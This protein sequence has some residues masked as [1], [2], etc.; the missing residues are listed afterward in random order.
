M[1]HTTTQR[2]R[3]RAGL[4][5]LLGAGLIAGGQAT[6]AAAPKPDDPVVDALER[7]AEPL[8]TTEPGGAI[9]DLKPLGDMVGDASVVTT[10]EATHSSHEF[11]TMQ[12][13]IFRYL[14]EEK[15]FRTF[16]RE[17]SWSTGLLLDEYIQTGK[18]DPREIMDRELEV[19][20]QVFDN[21]EFLDF[22]ESLRT[23]NEQQ[24][25]EDDKVQIIGT[26]VAFAGPVLFEKVDTYLEEHHRHLRPV[27]DALYEGLAPERGVHLSDY[28]KKIQKLPIGE[29]KAMAAKAKTAL[30][31][32]KAQDPG[33]D[34]PHKQDFDRV[35]QHARSIAQVAEGYSFDTTTE[36]GMAAWGEHRDT[37]MADN[38]EWW[39]EHTGAKTMVST[40]TAHASYE[41]FDPERVP[42][43]LGEIL[44]ERLGDEHVN[45]GF[46]FAQ[47]ST[48]VLMEPDGPYKKHRVATDGPEH[49]EHTLDQVRHDDYLLDMRTAA[50]EAQERLAS[51]RKTFN[52]GGG[53]DP[54]DPAAAEIDV[55]LGESYDILVHLDEV[56]AAKR[57]F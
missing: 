22:V 27:I 16:A 24:E 19:F 51:P 44:R 37:S 57:L 23:Y 35:L 32:L 2:R 10:G 5:V 30:A 47:G 49:A 46:T 26:D 52:I 17:I 4:V 56:H 18:G 31:V 28:M 33:D 11:V 12:Q 36:E 50:P 25:D 20:Y 13:R 9:D 53:I 3:V 8:R 34:S 14:V 40:F 15:G 42:T 21:Q 48:N 29:R 41:P 39:N 43:P 7:S 45:A 38:I 6:V 1:T 54:D 55:A